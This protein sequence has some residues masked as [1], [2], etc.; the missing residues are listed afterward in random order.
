MRAK[1]LIK[2]SLN[3]NQEIVHNDTH[4]NFVVEEELAASTVNLKVLFWVYTDDFR[5]GMLEIR[6]NVIREIK[7]SLES[8]GFN[9]PADITELK[10][11]DAS[12]PIQVSGAEQKLASGEKN[13]ID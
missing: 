13:V 8:N 9:L 10:F 7:T 4:V 3:K 12:K 6:G 11:Y 1:E 5:R 2:E